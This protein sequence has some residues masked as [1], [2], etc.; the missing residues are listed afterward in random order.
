MTI[1]I[2]FACIGQYEDVSSISIRATKISSSDQ[3]VVREELPFALFPSLNFTCER[4]H[5]IRLW[6]IGRFSGN[7]TTGT[8]DISYPIF[9]LWMTNSSINQSFGV[10]DIPPMPQKFNDN[11]D[12]LISV[13]PLERESFNFTRGDFTVGIMNPNMNYSRFSLLYHKNSGPSGPSIYFQ[14]TITFEPSSDAQPVNVYPLLA[15]E[16]GTSY[17]SYSYI[18][19]EYSVQQVHIISYPSA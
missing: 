5:I 18:I 14:K 7:G 9:K 1:V 6:F 11:Q 3:F 15:A 4:G 19:I 10:N 8:I 13:D 12:Q 17:Y 2:Y 16:T